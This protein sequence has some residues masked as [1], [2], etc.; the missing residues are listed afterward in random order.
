MMNINMHFR[1]S[2]LQEEGS[3]LFV[4]RARLGKAQG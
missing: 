1:Q 3:T 4:S 2:V